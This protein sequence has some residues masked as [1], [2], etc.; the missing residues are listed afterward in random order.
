[1]SK[2]PPALRRIQHVGL[3][4]HDLDEAV[5]FY[6]DVMGASGFGSL[7]TG[8]QPPQPVGDMLHA[9]RRGAPRGIPYRIP[10]GSGPHAQ[11]RRHESAR[12][13]PAPRRLR[14]GLERRTRSLGGAHSLEGNQARWRGRS[15]TAPRILRATAPWARTAPFIFTIRAETAS[16]FSATWPESTQTPT[17]WTKRGTATG[18]SATDTHATTF[19]PAPRM[20]ARRIE[21]G[22]REREIRQSFHLMRRWRE[23]ETSK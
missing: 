9:L 10:Q 2:T 15:S 19:R 18:S 5:D 8:R 13:R 3:K 4:V 12:G 17:G 7:R 14:G 20:E 23:G 16:R 11:K 21:H 22:G 1:M 6:R